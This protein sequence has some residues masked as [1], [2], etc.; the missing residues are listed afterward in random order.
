MHDI[1]IDRLDFIEMRIGEF[2][3]QLQGE[4]NSCTTTLALCVFL[5]VNWRKTDGRYFSSGYNIS[6]TSTDDFGME[7][8]KEAVAEAIPARSVLGT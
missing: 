1:Y 4:T 5:S 8:L 2:Q 3:K 6:L 7:T